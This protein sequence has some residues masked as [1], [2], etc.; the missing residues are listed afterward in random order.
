MTNQKQIQITIWRWD[1]Q[2][3]LNF[4]EL[5]W[6]T[7]THI[8]DIHT[9]RIHT[10]TGQTH[11]QDIRSSPPGSHRLPLIVSWSVV[12]PSLSP[13]FGDTTRLSVRGPTGSLRDYS[14]GVTSS[15]SWIF[16]T[17][18]ATLA[19]GCRYL[20]K[21]DNVGQ[22]TLPIFLLPDS[23]C[24]FV[25]M[26][27][28]PATPTSARACLIFPPIWPD[29]VWGVCPTSWGWQTTA[30]TIPIPVYYSRHNTNTGG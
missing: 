27:E 13:P 18:P 25:I 15:H 5:H 2:A 28:I 23:G 24:E 6:T 14:G 3:C 22:P 30:A 21:K 20:I 4:P 26:V 19:P 29:G 8:Q 12:N 16:L 9:Y 10:Y 17:F 11:I 7:T 1:E